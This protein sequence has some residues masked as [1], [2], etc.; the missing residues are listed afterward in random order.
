MGG[1]KVLNT[2]AESVYDLFCTQKKNVIISFTYL[3]RRKVLHS[4]R[5]LIDERY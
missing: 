2:L 1:N 4:S 5:N 3:L